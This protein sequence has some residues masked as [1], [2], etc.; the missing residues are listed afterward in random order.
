[1]KITAS[2]PGKLVVSGEYAVVRA[3]NLAQPRAE[4]LTIGA[5]LWF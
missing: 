3:G 4:R 5:S 1:M 2:A